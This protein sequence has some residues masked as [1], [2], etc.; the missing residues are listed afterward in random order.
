MAVAEMGV[1]IR[2]LD[3]L[4]VR[5]VWGEAVEGVEGHEQDARV[6]HGAGQA[7]GVGQVHG[8]GLDADHVLTPLHRVQ[9]EVDVLRR[10]AGG[11]QDIHV[12][13]GAMA[14]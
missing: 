13:S 11:D 2:L 1:P 14:R 8:E 10:G 3:P 5:R 6:T 12:V 4:L 9:A 7:V